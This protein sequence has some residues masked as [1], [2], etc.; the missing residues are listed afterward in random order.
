MCVLLYTSST[1][2]KW[3]FFLN[4]SP[5]CVSL[6]L[7]NLLGWYWWSAFFKRCTYLVYWI[8]TEYS[9]D[10]RLDT[11][12]YKIFY[13]SLQNIGT[14][15]A[16]NSKTYHPESISINMLNAPGDSTVQCDCGH[17]NC[18][19]CNLMMNLELTDPNQLM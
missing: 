17:I 1:F 15:Y 11:F 8:Y 3:Y 18:P 6:V 7:I 14:L 9:V 4:F 12:T 2:L 10:S 5:L 13:L 16:P 19:L